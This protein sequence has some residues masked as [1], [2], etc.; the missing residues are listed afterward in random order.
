MF[1]ES[2]VSIFSRNTFINHMFIEH[3]GNTVIKYRDQVALMRLD[4]SHR[5]M[6]RKN[7]S[8]FHLLF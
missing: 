4:P 3:I 6:V 2:I 8:A 7:R 1:A 5:P